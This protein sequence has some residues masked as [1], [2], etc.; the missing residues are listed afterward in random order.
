MKNIFTYRNLQVRKI[1]GLKSEVVEELF[2]TRTTDREKFVSN[3]NMID[4][5]WVK[6]GLLTGNV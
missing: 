5:N 4:K 2:S 1:K 6:E 3:I